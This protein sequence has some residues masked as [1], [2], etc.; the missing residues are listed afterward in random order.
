MFRFLLCIAALSHTGCGNPTAVRPG[1]W[2]A[3][4]AQYR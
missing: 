4:K 2:G 1:T 3:I